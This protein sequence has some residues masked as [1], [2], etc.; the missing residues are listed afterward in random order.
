MQNSQRLS[1]VRQFIQS[2]HKCIYWAST[3]C[4]RL[5]SSSMQTPITRFLGTPYFCVVSQAPTQLLLHLPCLVSSSPDW[6]APTDT[7]GC[8]CSITL[9]STSELC[10]TAL[11]AG[12]AGRPGS[13]QFQPCRASGTGP[14]HQPS[15]LFLKPLEKTF[16]FMGMIIFILAHSRMK[17][18]KQEI[19]PFRGITMGHLQPN[20]LV[21]VF[22]YFWV[23]LSLSWKPL[24]YNLLKRKSG[25]N[26]HNRLRQRGKELRGGGRTGRLEVM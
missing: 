11:S 19:A 5:P 17:P 7:W 25:G 23:W 12:V 16:D 3:T 10:I 15:A 2:Y 24:L 8:V 4:P 6:R 26:G 20:P 13:S 18:K 22:C 21:F 1:T 14:N 9:G